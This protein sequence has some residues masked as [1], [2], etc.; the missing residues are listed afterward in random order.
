[1]VFQLIWLFLEW[2]KCLAEQYLPK[3]QPLVL[4]TQIRV[5]FE[6]AMFEWSRTKVL[7]NN[8]CQN[9]LLITSGNMNMGFECTVGGLFY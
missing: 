3:P 9:K 4:L 7:E 1:L 2:S 5:V 6:K 8:T